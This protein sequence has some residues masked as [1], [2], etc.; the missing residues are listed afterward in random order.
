MVSDFHALFTKAEQICDQWTA[1]AAAHDVKLEAS[2]NV[3]MELTIEMVT[4]ASGSLNSSID[5]EHDEDVKIETEFIDD[6]LEDADDDDA[7]NNCSNDNLVDDDDE[8]NGD[9]DD[10]DSDESSSDEPLAMH[11]RRI[12]TNRQQQMRNHKNSSISSNVDRFDNK[13]GRKA[14]SN[15]LN[16]QIM[17]YF[18]L[19]CKKCDHESVTLPQLL[20]HTK[21]A[22]GEEGFVECCDRKFSRRFKILEHIAWHTNPDAFKYT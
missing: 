21:R 1:I 12:T 17:E 19:A 9:E 4:T 7:L 18:S 10:D 20:A 3:A 13:E 14:S 8:S 15:A 22:H 16:L 11:Q 5:D 2:E 6:A